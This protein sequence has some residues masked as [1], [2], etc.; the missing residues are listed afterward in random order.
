MNYPQFFVILANQVARFAPEA[1]VPADLERVL[2]ELRSTTAL[3]DVDKPLMDAF[4]S[5]LEPR[6][7]GLLTEAQSTVAAAVGERLGIIDKQRADA[8]AEYQAAQQRA[9]EQDRA[10][11]VARDVSATELAGHRARIEQLELQ[12]KNLTPA[13]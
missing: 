6:I 2:T 12:I 11:Q 10:A 13:S 7:V 3:A 8:A 4:A 1:Q 9:V 5:L